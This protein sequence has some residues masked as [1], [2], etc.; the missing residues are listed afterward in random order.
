MNYKFVLVDA[1]SGRDIRQWILPPPVTVGRC[2]TAEITI[3]DASISRRHCQ[4][5]MDPHGSLV[6]RDLGSKNGV[7]VD[8]RRVD[9][10][11]VRPGTT[12]RIG[13]VTLRA[14][15]TDEV[16]EEMEESPDAVE[17]FDLAETEPMKIVRP[18]AGA[19]SPPDEVG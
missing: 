3:P 8:Q 16:M 19:E 17:V 6:V 10:S 14:E 9:K 7:Y 4:F 2:P 15:L 12:I 5:L 1:D 11:V 13:T 18:D